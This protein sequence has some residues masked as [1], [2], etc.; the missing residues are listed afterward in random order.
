MLINLPGLKT[1]DI[2]IMFIGCPRRYMSLS[3]P[4]E[5][6]M[7]AFGISSLRRISPLGRS[8]PHYSP[9][10]LMEKSSFVKYMLMIS[11]LDHQMKIIA[12]SLMN[13]C[14]RSLRYRWLESLH[15]FLVFKS[16][17]W[18]KRFSSLKKSIPMI[19]SRGSIW[20]NVSQS[21]HQYCR[22]FEQAPAS[23]FVIVAR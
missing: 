9:R 14:R 18:E 22:C 3:K 1:L 6:G 11:S 15:S 12:K 5:L 7:N 16:S 20:M 21:R 4:Q 23:K 17:K 13:W 2:L 10:S 19:F 8:T